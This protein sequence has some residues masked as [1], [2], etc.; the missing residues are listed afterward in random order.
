MEGESAAS[1]T[2]VTLSTPKHQEV[3]HFL[4]P[5][6]T[7]LDPLTGLPVFSRATHPDLDTAVD[8]E[9]THPFYRPEPNATLRNLPH[10]RP[11]TLYIFGGTSDLSPPDWRREKMETT[12]VGV[13]GS[14][15]AK[16][17]RVKGVVL[18][19]VGHLIP[20]L[21]PGLCAEKAVEWLEVE[22]A[23]W[24]EEEEKWKRGWLGK[25]KRE[26]Q[27]VT[28]EW[29]RRVGWRPEEGWEAVDWGSSMD[30]GRLGQSSYRG[31]VRTLEAAAFSLG[32][33]LGRK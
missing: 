28:K 3:F 4:R 14:G 2:P 19:D 29:E 11:S 1:E 31:D 25:T 23:R 20:M 17:G 26:R 5:N 8:R 18:E 33:E 30:T 21:V 27:M 24:T 9:H 22:V 6:F 15:G 10:L 32:H 13:G 7:P 12:G 16:E